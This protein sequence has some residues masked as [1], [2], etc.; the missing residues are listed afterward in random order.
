M[1]T[2][3]IP[4]D[5]EAEQVLQEVMQ[6]A[7]LSR[8]EVVKMALVLLQE[9]LRQQVL[10]SAEQVITELPVT[11]SATQQAA[12]ERSLAR[13]IQGYP[14]GGSIPKRELLHERGE[15]NVGY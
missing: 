14:L 9:Q 15:D 6:T 11:W 8:S 4:L 3:Q 13:M 5:M 1:N 2:Y 7:N 10:L 12:W